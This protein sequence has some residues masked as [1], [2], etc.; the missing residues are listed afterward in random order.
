MSRSVNL[1]SLLTCHFGRLVQCATY[2][3]QISQGCAGMCHKMMVLR[4]WMSG[5]PSACPHW[6][7]APETSR[8]KTVLCSCQFKA[9]KSATVPLR[10][11]EK[12]RLSLQLGAL[13]FHLEGSAWHQVHKRRSGA[14]WSLVQTQ[15]PA[16]LLWLYPF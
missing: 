2:L 11:L 1:C 6:Q 10:N 13:H 14:G 12:L 4:L 7:L 5:T 9:D 15:F 8:F 16:K 3:S